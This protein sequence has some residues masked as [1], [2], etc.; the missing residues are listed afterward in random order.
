M[1]RRAPRLHPVLVVGLAVTLLLSGSALLWL[2]YAEPSGARIEARQR[3]DGPAVSHS[4]PLPP[5]RQPAP[6]GRPAPAPST[7]AGA[8]AADVAPQPGG[9]AR[10]DGDPRP[11]GPCRTGAKL[12]PTSSKKACA[13]K[14]AICH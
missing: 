13:P 7:P 4:R 3:A 6:G 9:G 11:D 5:G 10:P 1:R 14:V 8:T 2:S 12:V